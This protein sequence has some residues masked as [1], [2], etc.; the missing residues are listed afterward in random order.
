[1]PPVRRTAAIASVVF[2]LVSPGL[3]LVVGPW[4]LTGFE[5]GAGLLDAPAARIAGGFLVAAG[6]AVILGAFAR[7]VADGR[8]TP[9]PAAPPERLVVTGAYRHVR[10]P[11]YVATTAAIAGEALLLAQPVLLLA[12]AAYLSALATWS[13][14]RE[15]PALTERF[16]ADY[17]AYRRRVPGWL[18]RVRPWSGP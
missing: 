10:H 15:E 12:A 4:L 11:I 8:G 16:G 14:L 17:V 7:F 13:H 6:V 5:R 9:S 1:M 18:P 2:F 3:E